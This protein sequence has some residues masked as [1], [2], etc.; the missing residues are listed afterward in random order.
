MEHSRALFAVLHITHD[1][2][3]RAC[4]RMPFL[5]I[6]RDHASSF[7]A[8]RKK[9]ISYVIARNLM[10]TVVAFN[11]FVTLETLLFSSYRIMIKSS[12]VLH[13]KYLYISLPPRLNLSTIKTTMMRLT[14]LLI[15]GSPSSAISL[16]NM[17]SPTFRS[18]IRM[19]LII[20]RM[21]ILLFLF[22]SS[23][24]SCI[25]WPFMELKPQISIFSST[26][27]RSVLFSD[28]IAC[29]ESNGTQLRFLT[30]LPTHR[31]C[32]FLATKYAGFLKFSW[33]RLQPILQQKL[34][35]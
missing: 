24:K 31:L 7:L 4:V 15:L 13:E 9:V 1:T 27:V 35:L 23:N 29:N 22:L 10:Y 33:L 26:L 3:R 34:M 18:Q 28:R 30:S 14:N 17:N 6:G 11:T 12:I 32:D 20:T 21:D 16:T 25:R 2:A 8:A 19:L 5:I